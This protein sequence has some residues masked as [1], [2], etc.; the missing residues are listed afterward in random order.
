MIKPLTNN[1]LSDFLPLIRAYQE[2]YEVAEINE[3]K[4]RAFFAQ[5]HEGSEKGCLFGFYV[6]DQLVGFSTVYFTYS[7]TIASKVAVLNDLYVCPEHRKTGIGEALILA[8]HKF[9][10]TKDAVRLQWVTAQ[11]NLPAQALYKKLGAKNSS[12]EFYTYAT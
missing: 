4:N 2:F 6:S 3:A 11:T 10:K 7:S 12:W 8:S 9:A 5:F 1:N